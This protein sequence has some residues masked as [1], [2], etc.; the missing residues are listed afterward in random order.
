M[1]TYN[2]EHA[3]N[4]C[5]EEKNKAHPIVKDKNPPGSQNEIYRNTWYALNAWIESRLSRQKVRKSH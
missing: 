4:E 3:I 1:P 5:V 2:L